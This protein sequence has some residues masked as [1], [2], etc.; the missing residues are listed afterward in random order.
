MHVVTTAGPLIILLTRLESGTLV[1]VVHV[2]VQQRQ[3]TKYLIN[4][5]WTIS[6]ERLVAKENVLVTS[7][8]ALLMLGHLTDVEIAATT[9][10]QQ[11][12]RTPLHNME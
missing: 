8:N 5:E 6:A 2:E 4:V 9:Q 10:L 1:T 11:Q 12:W 3:C 7:E